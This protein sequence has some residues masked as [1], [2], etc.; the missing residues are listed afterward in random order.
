MAEK[1]T[2]KLSGIN[3]QG[4]PDYRGVEV[5]GSWKWLENLD[6]RIIAHEID[7]SGAY[8]PLEAWTQLFI[9]SPGGIIIVEIS[10]IWLYFKQVKN[11]IEGHSRKLDLEKDQ[12]ERTRMYDMLNN[13]P[14]LFHLQASDYSVPFAN[15]IFIKRF[16]DPTGKPFYSLMH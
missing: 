11:E 10:L 6:L 8:K 9:Y 14:I 16:G 12:N 13:L 15:K 2:N 7:K 5:V 3:L 1:A 4:Y